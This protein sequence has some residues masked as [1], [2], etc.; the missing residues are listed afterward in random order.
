MKNLPIF[1]NSKTIIISLIILILSSIIFSFVI[2][3]KVADWKRY[4]L[5]GTSLTI[6]V[7]AVYNLS[8]RIFLVKE[9]KIKINNVLIHGFLYSILIIMSMATFLFSQE[10]ECVY[11]EDKDNIRKNLTFYLSLTGIVVTTFILIYIIYMKVI[12]SK[13]VKKRQSSIRKLQQSVMTI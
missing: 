13:V 3:P 9:H 12:K 1:I 2:N 4:I 10:D 7:Y 8:I 11:K 6:L 5:L